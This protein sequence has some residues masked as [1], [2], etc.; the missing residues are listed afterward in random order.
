MAASG[1]AQPLPSSSNRRVPRRL[2]ARMWLDIE[3]AMLLVKTRRPAS[4]STYMAP[5]SAT[6]D[7]AN[8]LPTGVNITTQHHRLRVAPPHPSRRL[9]PTLRRR[10]IVDRDAA[11]RAR[12]LSDRA[13]PK[14]LR[15]SLPQ[16]PCRTLPQP[17]LPRRPPRRCLPTRRANWPAPLPTRH[18]K[19]PGGYVSCTASQV[20]VCTGCPPPPLQPT[21]RPL[22]APDAPV[23]ASTYD[24]PPDPPTDAPPAPK[25]HRKRPRPP[26]AV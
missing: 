24:T 13:K 14:D 6:S 18:R 21:S 9:A 11:P 4:R 10:P 16:P 17:P 7:L 1:R 22:P 3:H 20:S 19:T 25:P 12:W 8:P 15:P 5:S 2:D 26:T 23:A